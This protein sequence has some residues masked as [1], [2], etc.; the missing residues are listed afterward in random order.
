M[1][2]SA[3]YMRRNIFTKMMGLLNIHVSHNASVWN[4][5]PPRSVTVC[6]QPRSHPDHHAKFFLPR[7]TGGTGGSWQSY[8]EKERTQGNVRKKKAKV[9]SYDH[10]FLLAYSP[11]SGIKAIRNN[12]IRKVTFYSTFLQSTK[13]QN[14]STTIPR[15][16]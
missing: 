11:K 4:T 6:D 1:R 13:V 8:P 7:S 14:P 9:I 2:A 5:W 12:I 15:T 10:A 16:R 3:Q